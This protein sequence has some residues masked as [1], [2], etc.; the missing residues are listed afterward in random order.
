MKNQYTF[1]TD[2]EVFVYDLEANAVISAH[3]LLP[4]SKAHPHKTEHGYVQPDGVAAE[5]NIPPAKTD[6]EFAQSIT[7]VMDDLRKIILKHRP[8]AMLLTTPVIRFE[9]AY[10][11]KL[12][13]D[14]RA[15]GCMPDYNAW[16]L[17]KNPKPNDKI[18]FRSGGFHLHVGWDDEDRDP[19][20]IEHFD[21]CALR[22]RQLE[23]S[24]YPASLLWDSNEDRRKLYGGM[25]SF[26]P[27]PYGFEWRSLS[28]AIMRSKS[29]GF[30]WLFRTAK[31]SMEDYDEGIEYINDKTIREMMSKIGGKTV[32]ESE[33]RDFV[34]EFMPHE[35]G[36][37]NPAFLD[38]DNG[39]PF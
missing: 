21:D 36:H 28:N 2:P 20:G 39:I 12:P 1:G 38:I 22:V 7:S 35:F 19:D 9:P 27:K 8:Q 4:G 34:G 24:I 5:F 15:L 11:A 30:E 16:S 18:D 23:C 37:E 29:A 10:W 3:D 13:K 14:V 6:K 17:G 33:L 26:R 25:G 32:T 31:R